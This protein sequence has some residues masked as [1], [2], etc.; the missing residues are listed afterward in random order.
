MKAIIFDTRDYDR[1]ALERANE[2]FGHELTFLEPR[3]DEKTAPL[4]QGNDAI[5]AFVNDKLDARTL[6]ALA[7][8]G[9]RLVALRCAGYNNLDLK[10]A[11]ELA[12]RAVHVPSYTPHAVA[13]HVFALL[14]SLVRHT[15]RAH[16]RVR[17]GNFSVEGLVGFNLHGKNFG[18]V[19]LGQ[20]GR[21]VAAIAHGMGCRLLAYDPIATSS[22]LP[23]TFMPLDEVL[24]QSHV[25]SLHAP[26]TPET[27]HMIDTRR[28]RLMPRDAV[29][30]NTSRGGLINTRALITHLKKGNLAGVGLDVYEEEEFGLLSRPLERNPE[31]RQA[32]PA[33]DLP[34]RRHHLAYGISH[35]RSI[36]GYRRHDAR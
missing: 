11:N 2:A 14:L 3:L 18:I 29:L 32:G 36:A 12:L 23:I 34:K 10:A 22:D 35:A 33:A 7:K 9:V 28:L 15:I 19:G 1:V 4:A 30:I 31:R 21:A 17:D 5:V 26:L 25:V 24:A 20:I 8:V 16:D 27:H 6:R 13:E